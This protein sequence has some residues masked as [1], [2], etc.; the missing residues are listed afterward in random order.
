[1]ANIVN[2]IRTALG[3]RNDA[4]TATNA[5]SRQPI[6]TLKERLD[7]RF[8]AMMQEVDELSK[9]NSTLEE[10][11]EYGWI[12]GVRFLLPIVFFIG[13]GYED[14]LFMTGFRYLSPEPFIL[15]MYT[16]G[17]GLE[18]LRVAMVYSM[19]FSKSEGRAKAYRHQ[20]LF[21][22]VM[23]LGCGV[24]QLA[25]ALVI[26][27]LGSDQAIVGNNAVAH[28]ASEIMA[29]IPYLV[30]IAIGIRVGLCAIAD[31]ACSGYL[32]KKKETVEQKVAMITTKAT[33]LQAVV[34]AHINAQT[35]GDNAQHFQEVIADERAELKQLRGNQKKLSDMVFEAGMHKFRTQ[36]EIEADQTPLLG[37][38]NEE[39]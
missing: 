32:H 3:F 23:S 19:N 33:N 5:T 6:G 37:S 9:S 25:S 26:Q 22:I 30:Y 36:I 20:F 38:S 21:W 2:K 10:H 8:E 16:I 35:M 7:A 15:L 28:G 12:I 34:Q 29:R 31:W 4:T 24:A 27:A 39:E 13:F 11:A 14:G 1:M 17:Y 18:G